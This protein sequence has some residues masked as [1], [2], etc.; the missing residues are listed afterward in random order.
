M[1]DLL[2]SLSGLHHRG[3][4]SAGDQQRVCN[5]C[6][7]HANHSPFYP[8]HTLLDTHTQDEPLEDKTSCVQLEACL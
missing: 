1:I 3:P 7:C 6:A 8:L 5:A 2:I 4:P